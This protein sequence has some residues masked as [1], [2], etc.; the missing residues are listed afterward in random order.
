MCVRPCRILHQKGLQGQP[1]GV[2]GGDTLQAVSIILLQQ[3]G[4]KESPGL[5]GRSRSQGTAM[6]KTGASQR[7]TASATIL[8][9]PCGEPDLLPSCSGL[10][11]KARG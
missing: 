5:L 1:R 8:G 6:G 7:T 4:P 10:R 2:G 9:A 11:L 3:E